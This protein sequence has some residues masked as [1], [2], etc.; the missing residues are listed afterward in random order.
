MKIAIIGAG[1]AGL[2]LAQKLASQHQVTVFEKAR[3]PGGR[4]STRRAD[5]YAFDHGAQYFTASDP[6]FQAFIDD[7]MQA[8]LIAPWPVEIALHGGARISDKPKYVATPGMNAVCKALARPLDVQPQAHVETL[9]SVPGGW[10]LSFKD[11]AVAGPFD[12]VV[13]TAPAE[14][15][16]ILLPEQF[17]GQASLR[18]VDMSGCFALMLGFEGPVDLPFAALKSATPPIGWM[19]LNSAKPGRPAAT[20]LLIQSDNAWAEAHLDNDP[21][22]VMQTLLDAGSELTGL[23]LASASH[24]VVHRWRYAST[25]KSAGR[26]FLI[27]P[28]LNLAACGDWCLGGKVEAAYLSAMALADQ[29]QSLTKA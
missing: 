22:S 27:D 14:Q 21:S 10:Q 28:N 9:I 12:W 7:Q 15:T 11:G 1:L 20:A 17:S 18:D 24:Q 13:S 5:P 19:A 8:G 3:G 29:F 4:M 25:P 2:T 6:Q 26:P 23:D 16:Q